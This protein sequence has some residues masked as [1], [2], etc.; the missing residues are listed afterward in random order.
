M[1]EKLVNAMIN[2]KEQEALAIAKELVDGGEDPLKILD[3]CTRAMETVGKRFEREEYFL[4]ELMMA[5]EML[6]QISEMVKPKLT[7]EVIREKH[8]RVLMGTVEGDIHNIGKDIVSFLLD[9]NGFEVKDIGIDVPPRKF[10]DEIKAFQPQVV[11][12]SGLLT[13]AYDSMKNTVQAI[14][15]AGL[16]GSVKI[17]IGGGQIS[18]KVKEYSGADAYGKD[19]LQGVNLVKKWIGVD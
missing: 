8:G 14:D 17:M 5:G 12:L 16:R 19:A 15:Q 3:D 18:D 9:V 6:R 1:S 7:G 10:V 13:L 2:M 11:G 4:P